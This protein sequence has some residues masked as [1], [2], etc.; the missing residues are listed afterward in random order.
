MV[1]LPAGC[2]SDDT[3]LRLATSRSILGDGHF[4]VETF[5][6]GTDDLAVIRPGWREGTKAAA[7]ALVSPDVNWF[8]NFFQSD[9][10]RYLD[11]GGNG[12]AMRIQPHV[13]AAKDKSQPGIVLARCRPQRC[14][15]PRAHQGILGA[16]FH[17][18]CLA[19][20]F[21]KRAV[22]GPESWTAAI[23]RFK[24]VAK[25]VDTDS[26]LSAF[27]RPVWE[28]LSDRRLKRRSIGSLMNARPM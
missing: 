24:D 16:V 8:S 2:Y 23:G 6:G 25:I 12:A 4:D 5:K 3:Q 1:D 20:A 7:A 14:L 21:S 13:W 22:P 10:V 27:W 15:Q 18:L 26:E 19:D 9:D 11:A 17:A 28:E